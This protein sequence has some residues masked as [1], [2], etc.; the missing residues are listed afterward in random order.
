MLEQQKQSLVTNIKRTAYTAAVI[1]VI[2]A[3]IGYFS[4][5]KEGENHVN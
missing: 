5:K 1:F 4:T 3:G 2:G